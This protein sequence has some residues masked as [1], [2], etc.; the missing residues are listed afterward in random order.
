MPVEKAA[1]F[2]SQKG[3]VG[4]NIQVIV[5]KK[6]KI[7]FRSIKSRGAS[8]TQPHSRRRHYTHDCLLIG[9]NWQARAYIS[10]VIQ[11][12]PSY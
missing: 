11:R 5:D 8:M 9:G 1:S 4:I 10:W 2:Y 7:F 12:I 3:Y 6:K